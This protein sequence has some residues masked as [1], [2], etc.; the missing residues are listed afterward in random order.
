MTLGKVFRG[1][2]RITGPSIFSE[3]KG[4]L[5]AEAA[6]KQSQAARRTELHDQPRGKIRIDDA[7]ELSP[8]RCE[9]ERLRGEAAKHR[10]LILLNAGPFSLVST[11]RDRDRYGRQLRTV[12]RQGRSLGSM[13][14]KEGLARPWTGSRQLWCE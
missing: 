14:V 3:S 8:P 5:E 2:S 10:L 12:E 6:G 7:P 4:I 11:D 13:L 1:N 9:A